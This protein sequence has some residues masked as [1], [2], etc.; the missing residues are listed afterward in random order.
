MGKLI[1]TIKKECK[2]VDPSLDWFNVYYEAY[3]HPELSEKDILKN[4]KKLLNG[5]RKRVHLRESKQNTI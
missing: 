1:D 4:V 3:D 2:I 5:V